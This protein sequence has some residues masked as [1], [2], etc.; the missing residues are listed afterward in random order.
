MS[1]RALV[2]VAA[3]MAAAAVAEAQE[4]CDLTPA[5]LI[6]EAFRLRSVELGLYTEPLQSP[7]SSEVAAS[8]E[9]ATDDPVP[10]A[11]FPALFAM[12]LGVPTSTSDTGAVTFNL[13]PFAI[14]T[15]RDPEVIDKQSEYEKYEN[16]RRFG[17]A[18]TLGG[19]G[20]AFD[21][22]GDGVIDDALEAESLED[23]V[24]VELRWRFSGSRDRRDRANARRYFEKTGKAFEAAGLAFAGAGG[25]LLP[26]VLANTTITRHPDSTADNPKYCPSQAKLL[27][28]EQTARIDA[29]AATVADFIE[30]RHEVLEEIDGASVWT[31]VL[32]STERKD[33]FGPDS[34]WAGVRGGGGLGPDMGWSFN[35]DYGVTD[36][37]SAADD[38]KRIKAGLEWAT[39]IWKRRIGGDGARASVSGSYEKWQDLPG[40]AD[41]EVAKVNFKLSFPLTDTISIPLSITWANKTDLLQDESEIRG[42]IGFTFDF[43]GALRKALLGPK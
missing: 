40:A 3:M 11:S 29:A 42:Y 19:T 16:L 18:L 41:D 33:D 6:A 13:T 4:T 1:A 43:D 8:Q 34:W 9:T 39:L 31:F 22:D 26:I 30:L 10:D 36:S 24:S 25:P 35:L 5:E 23:I 12:H 38:A 17:L 21:R 20:E 2:A 15:T 7:P 27:V 37:L 28:A 32:G 14:V